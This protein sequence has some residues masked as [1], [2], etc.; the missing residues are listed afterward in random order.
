MSQEEFHG[1]PAP[2]KLPAKDHLFVQRQDERVQ[3]CL[4]ERC[5]FND[6]P[7]FIT[8]VLEK[9]GGCGL[10]RLTYLGVVGASRSFHAEVGRFDA[11][12][13]DWV[14]RQ[15]LELHETR[16]GEFEVIVARPV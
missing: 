8:L 12:T 2:L 1:P 10:I 13:D 5:S 16:P 3:A 14:E 4:K 11:E 9:T 7:R 15:T 6:I